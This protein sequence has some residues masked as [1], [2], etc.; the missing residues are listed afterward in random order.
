MDGEKLNTAS[1]IPEWEA[2][3]AKALAA[4]KARVD[5]WVASGGA[6]A[7]P[8][9]D[10]EALRAKVT[11][12]MLRAGVTVLRV[13]D[14]LLLNG[15]VVVTPGLRKWRW[16]KAAK[17]H[18]CGGHPEA[19][20][21][22]N[23]GSVFRHSGEIPSISFTKARLE[24]LCLAQG[25][26]RAPFDLPS[27]PLAAWEK[28]EEYGREYERAKAEGVLPATRRQVKYVKDI[29]KRLRL[30]VPDPLTSRAAKDFIEGNKAAFDEAREA[31]RLA[32]SGVVPAGAAPAIDEAPEVRTPVSGASAPGTGKPKQKGKAKEVPSYF[33]LRRVKPGAMLAVAGVASVDELVERVNEVR[34]RAGRAPVTASQFPTGM[35]KFRRLAAEWMIAVGRDPSALTE[36]PEPAPTLPLQERAAAEPGAVPDGARG[37]V[38]GSDDGVPDF[39]RHLLPDTVPPA[40]GPNPPPAS[41]APDAPTASDDG[42]VP[43]FLR[44]LL[45][46]DG[47]PVP[48][49]HDR[50]YDART[51]LLDFLMEAAPGIGRKEGRALELRFS[52]A[53]PWRGMDHLASELGVDEQAAGRILADALAGLDALSGCWGAVGKS[54][55][56]VLETPPASLGDLRAQPWAPG[57]STSAL[58]LVAEVAAGLSLVQ[59]D[60][61]GECLLPMPEK[62]ARNFARV[63]AGQV[64]NSGRTRGDAGGIAMFMGAAFGMEHE[65]MARRMAERI[66]GDGDDGSGSPPPPPGASLADGLPA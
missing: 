46:A 18:D 57:L 26:A 54:L 60:G 13:P 9:D 51:P 28:V 55:A 30:D 6:G 47:V 65:A 34:G 53:G 17:W 14:G 2:R 66:I 25:L 39:L 48:T 35:A 63:L 64:R 33:G 40:S 15:R 27:D 41:V 5:A 7:A 21:R 32:K 56:P 37:G 52:L 31:A 19:L 12:E 58:V 24:G 1:D 61:C 16:P 42:D 22:A 43:G 62:V 38:A 20:V 10:G 44:H 59:V 4:H 36:P 29:A 49:V 8:P 50:P 11:L 23:G 45:P 3:L